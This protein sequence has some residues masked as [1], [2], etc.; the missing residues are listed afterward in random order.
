MIDLTKDRVHVMLGEVF[1]MWGGMHGVAAHHASCLAHIDEIVAA[2][3]SSNTA[4][5]VVSKLVHVEGI[6]TTIATGILWAIDA[7]KYVPFDKKTTGYCLTK[8][9]MHVVNLRLGYEKVCRRI[10]DAA[11][12]EG[13]A[14][15]TIRALVLAAEDHPEDLWV[16]PEWH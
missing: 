9:W 3:K 12:G 8:K 16:S 13:K 5:E 10:V 15:E 7:A 6:G 1:T 11:V 2:F 14:H 4:D